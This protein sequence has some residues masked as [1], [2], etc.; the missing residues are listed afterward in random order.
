MK[1]VAVI[2]AGGR[3]TRFWPLSRR[4]R[5]KQLLTLFGEQSMLATS[6]HRLKNLV[7]MERILVITGK[8]IE[9][10]VR[11]DLP[12]LPEENILAEPEGRNTAPC[13]AWAAVTAKRRFGSDSVIAVLPAD[14]FISDQEGFEKSFISAA[15]YAKTGDIVTIGV[16]PS[17]PETGY[18]YLKF[19]ALLPPIDEAPLS[20]L[21]LTS[22][23]EKPSLEVAI[24]YLQDGQYLWNSGMFFFSTQT[25]LQ[26]FQRQLPELLQIIET[27]DEASDTDQASAVLDENFSRCPSISIDYGIME[28]ATRLATI[29]ASFGWSDVGNWR[30]LLDFRREDSPNFTAGHVISEDCDGAVLVADKGMTLVTLGVQDVAIIACSDVTVALP[31][32]RAQ[33]VRTLVDR[34]REGTRSDLLD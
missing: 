32:E 8:D 19:G 20:G 2:M 15:H 12:E 4:S 28:N 18:G 27:I 9:E 6:V 10:Q 1:T 13:V 33:E 26:E 11:N 17:H 21:T 16:R 24:S 5:P 25:I 29:P 22:F 14:H 34:V 3:G 23:V 31:I 7:P 30:A